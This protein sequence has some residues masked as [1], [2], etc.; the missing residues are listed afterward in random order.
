MPVLPTRALLQIKVTGLI[1]YQ[2]VNGAMAQVIPMH[3]GTVRVS[4]D[5]IVFIDDWEAL[6]LRYGCVRVRRGRHGIRKRNP[7]Q[8]RELFRASVG[9][10]DTTAQDWVPILHA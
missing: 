7:L 5:S 6:I 10:D 1:K 4:Q 9:S 2:D 8:Q 3:L